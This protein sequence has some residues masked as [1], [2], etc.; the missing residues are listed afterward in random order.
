M[1]LM[2]L[3]NIFISKKYYF[4]YII[5]LL[6][7]YPII[8][9][10]DFNIFNDIKIILSWGFIIIIIYSS[11]LINNKNKC[12]CEFFVIICFLLSLLF[13]DL[14]NIKLLILYFIN[15]FSYLFLFSITIILFFI[16]LELELQ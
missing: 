4:E 7:Y 8:F 12:F 5:T 2:Y 3:I 9:I 15:I 14:K 10:F 6:F 13:F 11:I 1:N 16:E